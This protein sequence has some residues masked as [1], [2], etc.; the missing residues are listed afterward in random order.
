MKK[1]LLLFSLSILTNIAF[2]QTKDSV[3]TIEQLNTK[4]LLLYQYSRD[5]W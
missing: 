4:V 1:T 3:L 5:N 2:T